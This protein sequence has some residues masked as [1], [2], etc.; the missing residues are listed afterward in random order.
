MPR[1]SDC[2]VALG[3]GT[4]LDDGARDGIADDLIR[5]NVD[6]SLFTGECEE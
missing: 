5:A 6:W 3:T 4:R 1:R 2:F